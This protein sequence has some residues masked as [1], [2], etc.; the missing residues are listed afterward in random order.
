MALLF[1]PALGIGGWF[2]GHEGLVPASIGAATL[3]T[4]IY[5]LIG[6]IRHGRMWQK[7]LLALVAGVATG[8]VPTLTIWL[9]GA[10]QRYAGVEPHAGIGAVVAL[11]TAL[12]FG[13][14]TLGAYLAA[15]TRFGF[16]QT[17]AFTALAHPGYKTLPPTAGAP[18]RSPD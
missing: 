10:L 7:S 8:L 14:F 2:A 15:L 16:E 1:I 17:Q 5:A 6:G 11:G 18:Q 3:A 4:V 12:A 13:G 9:M